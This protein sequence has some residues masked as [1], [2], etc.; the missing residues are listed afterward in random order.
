[1]TEIVF[2]THAT[3]EH[4]EAG[5]AAGWL[6]GCL[7]PLGRR[8]A[9]ELGERRRGGGFAAVFSSDLRRAVQ[10]ARI[11]VGDAGTPI[12]LDWRLRECDYG[13]LSGAPR[14]VVHRD[15]LRY[16]DAAYPGGESWRAAV[17]RVGR[18]VDDLPPRWS[19]ERILVIG[20]IATRWGFEH[21]LNGVTLEQLAVERWAWQPGWR[22]QLP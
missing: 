21:R 20:H 11:A 18:F 9:L 5:V 19:G 2:E 15:R 6:H 17:D 16:L 12:L 10:T 7:S 1:M 14:E 8:Q 13:E 22:Y 4:N 3:S